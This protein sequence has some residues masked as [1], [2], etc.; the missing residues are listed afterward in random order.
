MPQKWFAHFYAVG[1]LC[2]IVALWLLCAVEVPVEHG[3]KE[4]QAALL[5][6]LC[7]LFHLARRLIES[8]CLMSYPEDAFMHLIAYFFGLR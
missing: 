1:V 5:G 2:A 3:S 7:L 8:T 4:R 6:M